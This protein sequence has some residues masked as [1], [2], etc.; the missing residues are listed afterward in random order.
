[1]NLKNNPFLYIKSFG[2][3]LWFIQIVIIIL[4]KFN[5]FKLY[6]NNLRKKKNEIIN[7]YLTKNY[8]HLINKYKK[9]RDLPGKVSDN[10]WI[11]WWQGI[12]NAPEIV[13]I[14]IKS[15]K[16]Y[17]K[18]YKINVITK[19]N[20]G[21]YYKIPKY[22]SEKMKNNTISLTH[23]SDLLRFNLLKLYGGFW[24]DATIY[25]T[26]SPFIEKRF[27]NF[28]TVKFQAE[29][30]QTSISKGKWC[31]FFQGGWNPIYYCFMVDFFNEYWK[32]E[33]LIIDYFLIDYAVNIAYNNI[34]SVKRIFDKIPQN[35]E[36]IHE[37][38]SLLNKPFNETEFSQLKK[39]NSVHKLSY[40]EKINYLKGSY[41]NYILK[42]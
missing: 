36:N 8:Q 38:Q 41:I 9:V 24:I 30:D 18:G 34:S 40:K 21:E 32:K 29:S 13:K 25:L 27:E 39:T 37:L 12:N 15:I 42:K 33:Q 7:K 31:G 16:L 4:N 23:L 1:M 17:C 20:I 3:Y 6:K 35:N 14:C 2:L 19:N 28:Y 22:I 26:N 10:I 5:I 11:F